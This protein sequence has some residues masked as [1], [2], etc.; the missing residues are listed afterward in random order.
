MTKFAHIADCHLG[1]FGRNPKLREYNLQAFE[2]AIEISMERGVDFIII[3]GDL[4]H[5]PHPDMDIVNRAVQALMKARKKGIRIY[6]VYGSHDFNIS[7]ASLIDVLESADVFKKVVNYLEGEGKLAVQEDPSGISIAG[8]SGRKNRADVSY[9][10]ELDFSEPEGESIFVFHTSIAE[11]KP[12]DIH[13]ERSLPISSLPE[14]Y[15]YYAGGHIHRHIVHDKEK[16]IIYPGTTFGSSYI[17][18]KT[19]ERG[20]YIVEDWEP[21]YIPLE[22]IAIERREIDAEGMKAQELE[23]KLLEL[24]DKEVEAEVYLLKVSGTLVE[25]VPEDI[26]FT[27]IRSNIERSGAETVYLNRRGLEGK[28]TENI[29][30]K[31][32]REEELEEELL[33]EFGTYEDLSIQ[34]EED[35]LGVLKMEQKE[36]E[37]NTDYESRIWENAWELIK[38]R[39]EYEAEEEKKE[40]AEDQKKEK[41]EQKEKEIVDERET[42]KK[43]SERSENKSQISLTDFS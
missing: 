7:N 23:D 12:A 6:S 41:S 13:E 21:E 43:E 11:L 27:T 4:F 16:T 37:T 36:G 18:L 17:D 28:R 30:I 39:D 15:D 25:G 14:G 22:D 10:E 8:L 24:S 5:N 40:K 1:A 9:Y 29:R 26:D 20:F 31:E 38:Q 2:K 32:E 35:L 19:D 3:A 33:K 42:K 34:F